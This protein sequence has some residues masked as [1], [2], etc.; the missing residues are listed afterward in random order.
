MMKITNNKG[1]QMTFDNGLTISCQMGHG[2]YC[3]NR[4]LCKGYGAE[5][6]Q[7]ITESDNCEV[8]IWKNAG[9]EREDW[10]TDEIFEKIGMESTEEMVCGWVDTMTVAKLIAY[11]ST[12]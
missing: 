11:V 1:F 5:M 6:L 8:A 10:I 2:N 3:S 12:L 9:S 4:D 7:P